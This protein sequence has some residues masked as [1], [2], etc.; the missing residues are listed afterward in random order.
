[1]YGKLHTFT[2]ESVYLTCIAIKY[3][4]MKIKVTIDTRA[5][6][7]FHLTLIY[8]FCDT[9]TLTKDKNIFPPKIISYK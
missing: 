4:F 6:P 1:M 3:V 2:F 5:G 7:L 9:K 8:L